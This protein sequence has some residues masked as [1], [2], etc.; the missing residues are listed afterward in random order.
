MNTPYANNTCTDVQALHPAIMEAI[1]N[2]GTFDD[3]L[4]DIFVLVKTTEGSAVEYVL[5]FA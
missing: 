1:A 2:G 5:N 3:D 4:A